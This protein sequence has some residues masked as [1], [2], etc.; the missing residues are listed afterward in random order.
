MDLSTLEYDSTDYSLDV[1]N[2]S[3]R[4]DLIK[5]DKIKSC[6]YTKKSYNQSKLYKSELEE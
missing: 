2:I 5:L 3:Y 1:K 4:S 6:I